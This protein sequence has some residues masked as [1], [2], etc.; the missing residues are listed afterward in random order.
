MI[1][2]HFPDGFLWISLTPPVG[3]PASM[4]KKV[5][6]TL[7]NEQIDGDASFILN[8]LKSLL[9]LHPSKHLII[10]DDVWEVD[11]VM[12][13]V[14]LFSNYKVILTT[15]KM[16]INTRIPPKH[17]FDIQ[18]MDI[19]EAIQLLLLNVTEIEK[20]SPSNYNA[21]SELANNLYCWPLL[22]NLVH[23]QL[24]VHCIEW[25]ESPTN[26]ISTVQQKLFDKGMTA[27][28]SE[29]DN[30]EEAVKASITLSLDLLQEDEETLLYHAISS[31]GIG[32]SVGKQTLLNK[33]HMNTEQFNKCTIALWSHGLVTFSRVN[34]SCLS[35]KISCVEVHE[36]IAQYILDEMPYNFCKII[37]IQDMKNQADLFKIKIGDIK[38]SQDYISFVDDYLMPHNIN[39]L[40]VLT[41]VIQMNF[42]QEL[43]MLI[44]VHP[45]LLETNTMI[46]FFNEPQPLPIRKVYKNIK[47]NCKIIQT[48]LTNDRHDEAITWYSNHFDTHPFVSTFTKIN[49]F[50][51]SL[52]K[53]CSYDPELVA[54]IKT[55]NTDINENKVIVNSHI[56]LRAQVVS[57]ISSGVPDDDIVKYIKGTKAIIMMND[58]E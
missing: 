23:G 18:K 49:D 3:S 44:E 53:E 29:K 58:N 27:F 12:M 38:T 40:A 2:K 52:Q 46:T 43:N 51:R 10:L 48:L 28:D 22:L 21:V 55:R 16:D 17:C 26:A 33:S 7:T 45:K 47:D 19:N 5:Y 1:K 37:Y 54:V 24:Y 39:M 35:C 56:M 15:R 57:M 34:V 42:M 4:L 32:T 50:Y 6:T 8:K 25:G 41:R 36:V 11:D 20:L 31:V 14:D 9:V 13:F 30:R